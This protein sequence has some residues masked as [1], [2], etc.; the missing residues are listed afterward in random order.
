M[1]SHGVGTRSGKRR[2]NRQAQNPDAAGPGVIP[3]SGADR[4]RLT[5]AKL[6]QFFFAQR[7]EGSRLSRF[8]IHEQST[9]RRAEAVDR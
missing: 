8:P 6:V 2:I 9:E 3:V 4:N 5:Q 7:K 1:D